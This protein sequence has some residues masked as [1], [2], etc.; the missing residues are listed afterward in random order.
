MITDSVGQEWLPLPQDA[1]E[2]IMR[3]LGVSRGYA[4][5]LWLN[6]RASREVRS[7]NDDRTI[8]DPWRD[9]AISRDDLLGWLRRNHPRAAPAREEES[10]HRYRHPG[11]AALVEEGRQMIANGAANKLQAARK[12]APRAEGGTIEQREQRLR[13]LF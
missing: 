7:H 1:V 13:K 3:E 4:E 11:D 8:N 2:L 5:K 9:F 12:L 6:A 10:P